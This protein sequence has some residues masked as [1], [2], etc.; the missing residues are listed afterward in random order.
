MKLRT[1]WTESTPCDL[2]NTQSSTKRVVLF[3]MFECEVE[4]LRRIE[5]VLQRHRFFEVISG[6]ESG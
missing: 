3:L 5:K 1:P 4:R 6:T 2:V